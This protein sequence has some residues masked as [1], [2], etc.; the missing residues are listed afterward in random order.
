MARYN[1]SELDDVLP[2]EPVANGH[3]APF[4][5]PTE[6]LAEGQGRNTAL[7][8]L[9]RA[10]HAK[11]VSAR[12]I[13]TTVESENARFLPPLP[14]D[15]LHTLLEHAL[16]QADRPDFAA[17]RNGHQEDGTSEDTRPMIPVS[18]D[19]AAMTRAAWAALAAV[20]EPAVMF[21]RGSVPAR[22]E[23]SDDGTPMTRC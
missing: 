16:T 21:R 22:I 17:A 8:T 4:K 2:A 13:V 9:I 1:A 10:L 5:M 15:E 14:D 23:A 18:G 20:N 11:N 6:P 12:A 3:G 19:L 7:Y